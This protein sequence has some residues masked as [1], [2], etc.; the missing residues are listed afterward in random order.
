MNHHVSNE[1]LSEKWTQKAIQE[2]HKFVYY[3]LDEIY[4]FGCSCGRKWKVGVSYIRHVKI[5]YSLV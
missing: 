3:P 2:K 5:L 4:K 1:D